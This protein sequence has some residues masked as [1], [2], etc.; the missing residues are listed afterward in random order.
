MYPDLKKKT[1]VLLK[2]GVQSKGYRNG[3][4]F[5]KQVRDAVKIIN[6]KYPKDC[7]NVFCFWSHSSDHT[8]FAEDAF[9]VNRMNI[10]PEEA[11]PRMQDTYY[12]GT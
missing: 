6:V 11:Q 4:K 12:N 3:E 7:C 8:A 2:Y 5:I 9:N 1:W 10:Q